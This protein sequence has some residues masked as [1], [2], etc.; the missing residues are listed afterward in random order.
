MYL[1]GDGHVVGEGPPAALLNSSNPAVT[2]F[3]R[4]Q[5]DGPMAFHFPARAYL[6]DLLAESP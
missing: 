5:P 3:M 1:L 4:G 6:D 2:Q